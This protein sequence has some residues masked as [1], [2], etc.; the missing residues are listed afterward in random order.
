MEFFLYLWNNFHWAS[1]HHQLFL[2]AVHDALWTVAINV[3]MFPKKLSTLSILIVINIKD[4]TP[5]AMLTSLMRMEEQNAKSPWFVRE[6]KQYLLRRWREDTYKK[7]GE[8]HWCVCLSLITWKRIETSP[9]TKSP[10][11]VVYELNMCSLSFHI[12]HI[13]SW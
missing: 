2:S 8:L 4:W 5:Q 10:S 6:E 7:E 1:L 11:L 13:F 9:I 3:S 12:P